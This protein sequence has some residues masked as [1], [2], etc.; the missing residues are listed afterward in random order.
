MQ[1]G[2]K[3]QEKMNQFLLTDSLKKCQK[4]KENPI[5]EKIN[6]LDT[7]E[8]RTMAQDIKGMAGKHKI[9]LASLKEITKISSLVQRCS[10]SLNVGKAASPKGGSR[11]S[12]SRRKNVVAPIVV[13]PNLFPHEQE[14]LQRL[15][16]FGMSFNADKVKT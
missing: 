7:S 3:N 4:L 9:S 10:Q 15:E 14:S 5:M 6:S 2:H 12:R 13:D 11:S 16:S 8:L 1:T